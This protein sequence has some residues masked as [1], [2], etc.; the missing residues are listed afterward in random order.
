VS[1]VTPVGNAISATEEPAGVPEP[2][3]GLVQRWLAVATIAGLLVATAAAF[4]ITE[5]LKLTPSPIVGTRVSKTFSP[6]C[7]CATDSAS[8]RFRL[9]R[10]GQVEVDVVDRGGTIVQRLARRRFRAGW[11]SFRWF[12]MDVSGRVSSDGDYLIRVHLLSERRTIVLP[13]VIRLDTVAPRVTMFRVSRHAIHVGERTRVF[14]RFTGRAHPVVLVDGREA[15]YGRFARQSGTLDWFG[16]VGGVPV[17]V[18]VHRLTLDG[19]DDAG[20]TSIATGSIEVRVKAH[21]PKR[22]AHRRKS[23]R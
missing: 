12:G 9:R 7:R 21:P 13:N 5:R 6:V 14:Y 16:K 15:I 3:I 23:K 4:A 11:L 8:V 10:G 22:R 20:N 17:G 19:R 2:G 1:G 18:G